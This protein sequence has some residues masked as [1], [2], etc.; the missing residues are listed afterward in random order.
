M[1]R[2]GL[3]PSVLCRTSCAFVLRLLI[4]LHGTGGAWALALLL[5]TLAAYSG[6]NFYMLLM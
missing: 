4:V 1:A 5:E 3:S 2:M 6:L